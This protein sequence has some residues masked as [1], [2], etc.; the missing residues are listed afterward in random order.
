MKDLQGI[1]QSIFECPTC[2]GWNTGVVDSRDNTEA[3]VKLR[4]RICK[5]C[6][7]RWE[8]IELLRS[9]FDL[10]LEES[11]KTKDIEIQSL[12]DS[13]SYQIQKANALLSSIQKTILQ[14]DI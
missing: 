1:E 12:C 11:D 6:G 2:H 13:L 10:L 8:T 5:D 14:K 4:T 9:E 7:K 3:T